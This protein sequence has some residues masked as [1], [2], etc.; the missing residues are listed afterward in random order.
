MPIEKTEA[1]RLKS[2]SELREKHY[3]EPEK[4]GSCPQCAPLEHL[5][6]T[7]KSWLVNRVQSAHAISGPYQEV[8]DYVEALQRKILPDKDD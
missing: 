6:V 1:P 7:M 2:L 5:W 8:L 3:R 4:L